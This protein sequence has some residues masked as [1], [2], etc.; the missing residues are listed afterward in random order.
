MPRNK[1]LRHRDNRLYTVF[2]YSVTTCSVRRPRIST[3][4]S[5]Q[6]ATRARFA[7]LLSTAA[8]SYNNSGR[9]QLLAGFKSPTCQV[10]P[11]KRYGTQR[12][13]GSRRYGDGA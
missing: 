12:E 7:T 9:L 8:F 5:A 11:P 4:N 2:A 13:G 10:P 1:K 6:T 3:R